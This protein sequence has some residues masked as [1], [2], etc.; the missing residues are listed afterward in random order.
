MS[1][2]FSTTY[3]RRRAAVRFRHVTMSRGPVSL[4]VAWDVR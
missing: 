1:S 4:D 3:F 2:G